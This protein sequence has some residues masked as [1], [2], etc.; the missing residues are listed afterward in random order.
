MSLVLRVSPRGPPGFTG[1]FVVSHIGL[2]RVR[3]LE[4][5]RQE[6]VG[7]SMG[8]GV[9]I[10]LDVADVGERLVRTGTGDRQVE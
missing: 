5:G 10:G 1:V 4:V 9:V 3:V 8:I 2:R 6:S 7:L